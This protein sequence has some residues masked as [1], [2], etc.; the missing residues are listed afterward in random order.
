ML[1]NHMHARTQRRTHGRTHE[2]THTQARCTLDHTLMYSSIFVFCN[3]TVMCEVLTRGS[4][5][6]Y[7]PVFCV[8]Q[9]L[10]FRP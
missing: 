10:G 9:K 2:R 4:T 1:A 8:Q 6:S 5:V 3:K 7:L